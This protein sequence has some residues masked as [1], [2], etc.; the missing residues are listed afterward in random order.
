M[1]EK[2]DKELNKMVGGNLFYQK[3]SRVQSY[4]NSPKNLKKLA[5]PLEEP[6]FLLLRS[7]SFLLPAT[8]SSPRARL[9]L[10]L[11]S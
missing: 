11:R 1:S 9:L 5:P 3:F 7:A 4:L 6:H 8:S 10:L 2:L